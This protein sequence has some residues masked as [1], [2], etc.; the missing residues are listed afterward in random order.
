MT[1]PAVRARAVAAL[2][3]GL[4]L[5]GCAAPAADPPS[6]TTTGA[7]SAPASAA[8]SAGTTSDALPAIDVSAELG[9]LEEELDARV[10]VS[11]VDTGTGAVVEHR[12][13]ERFGFASTIKVFAVAELLRRVPPAE[14]EEHVTWTDADVAAAGYA[15]VTSA[16]P[17]GLTLAQL[18]EAAVRES[19]NLATNLV[20]ER[21]GGPAGLTEALAALG[22]GSTRLVD[23]EPAL[24]DV[25]PGEEANTTT[26]AAFTADL[27]AVLEPGYLTE[28][29]RDL[30]LT[31]MSGNATGDAL[32]RAG[33]P[34]GWEV[35]DKS[36]GAGPMR[37]DVAV[38]TPP[39]GAPIVLT[40]LTTRNDPEAPWADEL[41][42]RTAAVVLEALG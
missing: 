1:R 36:G 5:A 16:H 29:D 14:R 6:P 41:V 27:L 22:D 31:W 38:V 3:L 12:V 28:A 10:G 2:V 42:A 20:L 17:G 13:Q 8:P 35:Q 23:V 24:N 39:D 37:N 21:I 15:P 25:V 4:V 11:A 34:E 40:I 33:A 26:P 18:A 30:L 7:T 19:D 32:V 9:A